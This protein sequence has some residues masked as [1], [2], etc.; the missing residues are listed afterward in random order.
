MALLDPTD[1]GSPH[2]SAGTE[3]TRG[4]GTR[5]RDQRMKIKSSRLGTHP[6]AQGPTLLSTFVGLLQVLK[7]VD[8]T[9][10]TRP[11]LLDV[12]YAH[13]VLSDDVCRRPGSANEKLVAWR[14]T[15]CFRLVTAVL[16]VLVAYEFA[17][18]GAAKAME[19]MVP[20]SVMRRVAETIMLRVV[21]AV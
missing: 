10:G 5:I 17:G 7:S 16:V 6:V 3:G 21:K 15:L 9:I 19:V 18:A 1:V 13:H 8:L 4:R 11:W 12:E 14:T 20:R 2:G